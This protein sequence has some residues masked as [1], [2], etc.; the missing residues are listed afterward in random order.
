MRH[1]VA[2]AG[3]A[4]RV[5]IDSAGTGAW[6]VGEPPDP[7]TCE[8]A[9]K[10]GYDLSDLRARKFQRSDLVRFDIVLAMDRANLSDLERL[11][12]AADLPVIRLLRSFDASAPTGAEVPDPY[13]GDPAD[14]DRVVEICERACRGLLDYIRARL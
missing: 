6:H 4:N 9:A 12:G 3:L 13:S 11:A 7:R 5:T 8:A 10:Y 2:A 1:L 14:F